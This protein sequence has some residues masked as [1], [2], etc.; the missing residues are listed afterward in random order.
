M[1]IRGRLTAWYAGVL[2]ASIML[3][4]GVMYYELVVER[5]ATS[6]AGKPKEPMEEEVAEVIFFYGVPTALFTIVGGWW[7][8][9]KALGPLDRLTR[10]AERIQADNLHEPLPRTGN[11]DEVDRLS[12]VLNATNHRL[13]DSFQR[14]R[15]FTLH[16]SHELKTPLTVMRS[17]L[18]TALNDEPLSVLERERAVRLLDEMERLTHIVDSLTFLTKADA[19]QVKLK[20]ATLALDDLIRETMEDAQAL[21]QSSGIEIRLSECQPASVVGDRR[22]LRQLLLILADNAIK[23]NQPEGNVSL[24]LRAE[25]GTATLSVTNTGPGIPTEMIDRVFDRFFRCDAAHSNEVDGCGLGLT[26]ARW[27]V[28]AHDG[29]IQITSEPNQF[30]TVT[31]RLRASA[32]APDVAVPAQPTA[33]YHV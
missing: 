28:Q 12:E 3:M 4:A 20:T 8:L 26:I 21:A 5:Q 6:A 29:Q 24:T 30:T 13:D 14:I 2:L 27:I 10:A 31:V 18:E 33:E 7:L 25:A 9:R 32:Q 17:E 11:G 22:R 15:E 16:A 1:T 23:Y 19:G